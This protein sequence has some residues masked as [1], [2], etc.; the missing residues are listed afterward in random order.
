[1]SHLAS[2]FDYTNPEPYHQLVV[3][4]QKM[5]NAAFWN[6]WMLADDQS[7]MH[8]LTVSVPGVGSIESKLGEPTIKLH[9]ESNSPTLYYLVKCHSGT[10]KLVVGNDAPKSWD[11]SDWVFAFPVTVTNDTVPP[12]TQKYREYV[13]RMGVRP[14][15]FSLAEL[16]IDVSQATTWDRKNSYFKDEDWQNQSTDVQG[17]FEDFIRGWLQQMADGERTVIGVSIE[18]HRPDSINKNAPTF[19]PTSCD[20]AVYPWISPAT[21]RDP[22]DGPDENA[23][24]LLLMTDNIPPPSP[25]GL[26]YSGTFVD[27]TDNHQGTFCMNKAQFWDSWLLPLLQEINAMTEVY[28]AKPYVDANWDGSGVVGPRYYIGYNPD[29]RSSTDPYFQFSEGW[30]GWNWSSQRHESSG[31]AS[32][33]W[34]SWWNHIR[35][36]ESATSSSYIRF[37]PGGQAITISGRSDFHFDVLQTGVVSG[38]FKTEAHYTV[39]SNWHLNF[40]LGV[41]SD[42]GLQIARIDDPSGTPACT[43]TG[44]GYD[45]GIDAPWEDYVRKFSEIINQYFEN[46]LGA[47]LN[48]LQNALADQHK[49]FLPASG[50]FLMRD[51]LFN[52]RGDLMVSLFYNG[53]E[54]PSTAPRRPGYLHGLPERL[55]LHKAV[56][57]VPP[58]KPFEG[59]GFKFPR[60]APAGEKPPAAEKSSGRRMDD[61]AQD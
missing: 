2:F 29:H 33:D 46:N 38:P 7:P 31:E 53:A 26:P 35:V 10:L 1:M 45:E 36:N 59:P 5:I 28:P 16:F 11:V 4:S 40:A 20:T 27:A 55:P 57:R 22:S 49:L 8:M 6:M 23:L 25:S 3:Q 42:G 52:T 14:G 50:T 54:P 15:D 12:G 18:A 21:S 47:V 43:S 56:P 41:V 39:T 24:C 58:H 19:V 61:S 34:G 30:G 60:Q 17:R 48:S 32:S 9:V 51:A 44:Y 37:M 13:D